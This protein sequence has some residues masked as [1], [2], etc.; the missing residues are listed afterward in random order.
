MSHQRESLE[1]MLIQYSDS[2]SQRPK[3]LDEVIRSLEL[4]YRY[5]T[6][7]HVSLPSIRD[8]SRSQDLCLLLSK[9][10]PSLYELH[11]RSDRSCTPTRPRVDLWRNFLRH[12]SERPSLRSLHLSNVLGALGRPPESALCP[13]FQLPALK[14]VYLEDER[15]LV[16]YLLRHLVIPA[17]SNAH[18]TVPAETFD[19]LCH[20]RTLRLL[21]CSNVPTLHMLHTADSVAVT[22]DRKGKI[23]IQASRTTPDQ[24][25]THL[26][27]E[28]LA[29]LD[30]M[31]WKSTIRGDWLDETLQALPGGLMFRNPKWVRHLRCAGNISCI[32][33]QTWTRL[34]E[35]F[36]HVDHLQ[37]CHTE[38]PSTVLST[39]PFFDA[40]GDGKIELEYLADGTINGVPVIGDFLQHLDLRGLTLSETVFEQ[41][42]ECFERRKQ[43]ACC[44]IP[45]L[46]MHFASHKGARMS[47]D[48]IQ[49]K[50]NELT[51]YAW[52]TTFHLDSHVAQDKSGRAIPSC[53]RGHPPI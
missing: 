29:A 51:K 25:T 7:L 15:I 8:P 14:D 41:F 24:Q 13:P 47:A 34:L 49:A 42:R 16:D 10:I 12:L 22:V 1:E 11:V 43:I 23:A 53:Y 44:S 17:H 30:D 46:T 19:P 37:I 39:I 31:Y 35:F 28:L 20:V 32:T 45:E 48:E 26:T 6:S 36:P 52:A 21:A 9:S 18:I 4:H 40:F 5:I 33:A 27:L 38:H 3:S 2:S 50:A